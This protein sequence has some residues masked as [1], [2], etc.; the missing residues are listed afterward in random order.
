MVFKGCSDEENNGKSIGI[1]GCSDEE[2]WD[3]N[4]LQ[5]IN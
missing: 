4:R 5:K 3:V 2:H 1:K